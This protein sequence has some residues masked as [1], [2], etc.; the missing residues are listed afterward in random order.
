MYITCVLCFVDLVVNKTPAMLKYWSSSLL[1]QF[2]HTFPLDENAKRSSYLLWKKILV[3]KKF[4]NPKFIY[5]FIFY[6]VLTK[7]IVHYSFINKS[8]SYVYMISRLWLSLTPEY[9]ISIQKKLNFWTRNKL[10]YD[11]NCKFGDVSLSS[12]CGY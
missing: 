3:A 7:N 11:S 6:R 5:G 9:V 12:R 1:N 8:F 10:Y 2:M 4:E